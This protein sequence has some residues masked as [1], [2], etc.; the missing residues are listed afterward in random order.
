MSIVP[1]SGSPVWNFDFVIEGHRF[2]GPTPF[3]LDNPADPKR[4]GKN[5][6]RAQEWEGALKVKARQ[7]IANGTMTSAYGTTI[8]PNDLSIARMFSEYLESEAPNLADAHKIAT[9][10][11][12]IAKFF[13]ERGIKSM[14]DISDPEVEALVRWRRQHRRWERPNERLISAATVNR[15]T[16]DTLQ[17][18]FTWVKAKRRT[19]DKQKVKFPNEPE[20]VNHTLE[21]P[22]ERVRELRQD[23]DE[24]LIA[25]ETDPDY[26]AWR[27]FALCSGLRFGNTLLKWS[28]V[29]LNRRSVTVVGKGN[30]VLTL[31]LSPEAARI[32]HTRIGHHP[33]Y[34]FTFVARRTWTYRHAGKTYHYLKGK[35]YPITYWGAQ[36]HW[37]EQR[38]RAAE[39]CPSLVDSTG[40]LSYRIHDNRHTLG[41]RLLR[42][43]GNL[44]LVQKALGHSSIQTSTKYA[45]VLDDEVRAAMAETEALYPAPATVRP[46]AAGG[47]PQ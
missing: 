7:A 10:L 18:V 29:D 47:S 26:E 24:A 34:V 35:R 8:T 45:H 11:D 2:R 6:K 20:W 19:S 30:K 41:T 21:E 9:N 44:K 42:Q 15:S 40:R 33:E 39:Y 23:E 22:K 16:V 32:L 12:R 37:R 38:A 43:T 17:P 4:R 25:A 31:P 14:L 13:A 36:G 3:S 46:K 1:R 5:Y 28:Q 27:R